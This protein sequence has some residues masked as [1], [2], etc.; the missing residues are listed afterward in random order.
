V[1]GL[2]NWL[3]KAKD[4]SRFGNGD[5]VFFR[6]EKPP[7]SFLSLSVHN[8]LLPLAMF[9]SSRKTTILLGSLLIVSLLVCLSVEAKS[10]THRVHVERSERTRENYKNSH[11]YLL[12]RHVYRTTKAASVPTVALTDYE[13]VS[14]V[15]F[16]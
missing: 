14:H 1:G 15:C 3:E 8:F 13:D 4:I 5:R 11:D 9:S 12:H 6:F 10:K 7:S 16:L 2:F